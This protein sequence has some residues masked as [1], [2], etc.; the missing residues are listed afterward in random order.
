[1]VILAVDTPHF[2]QIVYRKQQCVKNFSDVWRGR[3]FDES[4]NSQQTHQAELNHCKDVM[5][6][7]MYAIRKRKMRNASIQFKQGMTKILKTNR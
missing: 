2:L 6:I 4:Q 7:M 3:P 5:E 1:L